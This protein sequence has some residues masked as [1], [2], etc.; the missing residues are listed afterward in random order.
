M[1]NAKQFYKPS[2]TEEQ[3][4]VFEWAQLNSGKYPELKF[5]YH[6][7][8]EGKRTVRFGAELKRMG[9]K[10]G[11]PDIVLPAPR[12]SYHGLYI[13]MKVGQNRPTAA[14]KE[15]LEFL[16]SQNYATA[17]CYSADEAINII[18][19]YLKERKGNE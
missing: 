14:Q 5:M 4:A 8:N 7:A 16:K 3:E 19:T 11:V 10:N 2:E 15:F 9:L 13:E 6:V 1:N 12:G 17:V 18:K